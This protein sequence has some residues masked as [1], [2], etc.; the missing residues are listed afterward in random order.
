MQTWPNQLNTD[1][2]TAWKNIV[3]MSN[4]VYSLVLKNLHFKII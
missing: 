4:F 1:S 2:Y 3:T